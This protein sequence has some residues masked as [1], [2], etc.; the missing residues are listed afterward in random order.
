M[1]FDIRL[2]LT[3]EAPW[4]NTWCGYRVT[5]SFS[6]AETSGQFEIQHV[7][8]GPSYEVSR[9]GLGNYE[10]GN[11]QQL[12][13][14]EFNVQPLEAGRHTLTVTVWQNGNEQA[15]HAHDFTVQ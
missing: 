6:G 5:V 10:L 1:A 7:F 13:T 2:D 4:A 11:G 9:G 15:S 12:T 3:S 14:D 8:Q